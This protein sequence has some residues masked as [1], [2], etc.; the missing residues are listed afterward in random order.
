MLSA[1]LLRQEGFNKKVTSTLYLCI[2]PRMTTYHQVHL[3]LFLSLSHQ[4]DLTIVRWIGKEGSYSQETAEEGE[5]CCRA[6]EALGEHQPHLHQEL[7]SCSRG[8][9]MSFLSSC[10][11]YF[12]NG[13]FGRR[14]PFKAHS[15]PCKITFPEIYQLCFH[16]LAVERKIRKFKSLVCHNEDKTSERHEER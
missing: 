7:F 16:Y 13:I 8:R 10:S 1:T 9:T 3:G 15:D 11:V 12:T 2:S 6:Q 4:T 5:S 14:E